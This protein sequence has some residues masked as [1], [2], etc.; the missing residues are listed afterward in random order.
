MAER[1]IQKDK[2]SAD[3][4]AVLDGIELIV[5]QIVTAASQVSLYA[6]DHPAVREYAERAYSTMGEILGR[7]KSFTISIREGMLVYESIPLYRLSVSARKFIDLFEAKKIHGMIVK[8]GLPIGELLQFIAVL[9]EPPEKLQGRDEIN[10]ELGRRGVR[11]I[12]VMQ[13]SKEE[14]ELKTARP[15][16]IIYE[17]SVQTVR[18]I[19]RSIM[20]K[21]DTINVREVDGLSREITVTAQ[22]DRHA[23]L[24]LSGSTGY[25]EYDYVHPVN[26]CILATALAALFTKDAA[27]LAKLCKAALLHDVGKTLIPP[28][29]LSKAGALNDEELALVRRH[30]VDGARIL[31]ETEGVGSL[32]A[33]VAFEH[34]MRYDMSGYP[35]SRIVRRIHP[36]CL[37]VQVANA[38]DSMVSERPYREPIPREQA[39]AEMAA[40][41][42]TVFEPTVL[43]EFIKMMGT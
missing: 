37:L 33:I 38:Y 10:R 8:Q 12:E 18:R 5:K 23:M 13:V 43:K 32:T 34:H 25:D 24:S 20:K 16:R 15:P 29:I 35:A 42:G 36:L 26:V 27:V 7:K 14:E 40:G 3:L 39:L 2:L 1:D 9:V 30:P 22:K 11:H 4:L 17:D 21:R 31:E 6:V 28:D 19:A 41:S